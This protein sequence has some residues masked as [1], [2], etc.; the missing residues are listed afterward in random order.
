MVTVETATGQCGNKTVE[1][2]IEQTFK[3]Q[4]GNRQE[5]VSVVTVEICTCQCGNS[6]QVQVSLVTV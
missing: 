1:T 4:C 3:G 2:C 5:R 6:R